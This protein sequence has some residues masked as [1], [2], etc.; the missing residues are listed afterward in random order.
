MR[1]LYWNC[2]SLNVRKAEAEKLA[3]T[4]DIVCL[5]ETQKHIIKPSDFQPPV[6]NEAGHGQLICIRKG[7]RFKRLDL[8]RWTDDNLHLCGIEL[9]D[10]PVRNI[11]NVYACNRSMKQE[12]WMVLDDGTAT[13]IG[14]GIGA[15]NM[16]KT[17]AADEEQK[18]TEKNLKN[19]L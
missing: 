17:L 12:N 5:Q 11:V 1:I 4:A 6:C 9:I 7:I 2:G 15:G 10:Q 18:P 14:I 13:A 16:N 8:T 3:Y 19:S